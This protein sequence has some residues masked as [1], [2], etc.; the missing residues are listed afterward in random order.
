MAE[1][2][3]RRQ[4]GRATLPAAMPAPH[5][6]PDQL[7]ATFDRLGIPHRTVSH[8]PLFTVAESQTLRGKI[9]GGH[10]KNL[11]LKDKKDAL[12]LVV[13]LEDARIELKSLHRRVG[14]SGRFSFGSADLMRATL[15]VEPGAVTPFAAMNDSDRRVQAVLDAAMLAQAT[16]N[17]HPLRNTMTTSIARDDLIKFL[18]ATGHP[19]R[20]VA[21][22]EP[23]NSPPATAI[24]IV[25]PDTI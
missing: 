18:D 7:F 24:A 21:L 2:L 8:P 4:S 15:G 17:F 11:F 22:S 3:Q 25:A 12:Y 9:P 1:K 6:T 5:A 16:L 10:T 19:P 13:A 20:V 14:A 23:A